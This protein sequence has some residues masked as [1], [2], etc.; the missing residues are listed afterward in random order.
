MWNSGK[1]IVNTLKLRQNKKYL[2]QYIVA[3]TALTTLSYSSGSPE[4]ESE[5]DHKHVNRRYYDSVRFRLNDICI[6]I[7]HQT[8]PT[9]CQCEHL[10]TRNINLKRRSTLL[11]LNENSKPIS[12][13]KTKYKVSWKTPIGEGAFSTV[14][15]ATNRSTMDKVAIKKI[16]KQFTDSDA[17]QNE[18]DAL[19]KIQENGG[20]PN[21]CSLNESFEDGKNFYLVL[22]LVNGGEMFDHLIKLGAYSEADSARL[23]REA[24]KA[25]CFIHGIGVVHGDLKPENLML[26]TDRSEDGTIKLVDFGCAHIISDQ[27]K[28]EPKGSEKQVIGGNTPAYC[29][30]EALVRTNVDPLKPS[31]DMWAL[32]IILYIML[33]GLHPFDMAGNASDEEIESRIKAREDPPL[34]N[35]PITAHLSQSAIDVIEMCIKWDANERITAQQ[36]LDHPWVRGDTAS[37]SKMT[38]ASKKLKMYQP[39]KSKLEAK[40]FA[41][42]FSWSDDVRDSSI[43]KKTSLVERAFIAIDTNN[44]GFLTSDD[45]QRHCSKQPGDSSQK[46]EG[47]NGDNPEQQK[48][49]S[50][51]GFEN[52][53]G[54]NMKNKY[55]PRGM[56]I[57][58]E[59][60]IGNHMYFIN[61]GMIEVKTKDGSKALRRQGDFFGEGALL[62]SKKLRSASIH[63]VTPVHAIE[64]SREY[65]EKYVTSSDLNIDLKEKD[66]TRKRNRAKTILRLQKNLKAITVN[67]GH[68]VFQE[69]DHADSLY[70]LE[71]G[72]VD[73]EVD[74]KKVFGVKPGD[75]FGEHSIIMR[76][77]RNTTAICKS[78]KCVVQAMA[79]K[80][81]DDVYNSSSSLKSSLRELCLRREFQKALVKKTKKEFP[82]VKDLRKVFDAADIEE[83]GFLNENQIASLL[84]S[85]D[86]SLSKEEIKE[87][88]M[89]L[90]LDETGLISFDE[91]KLIFGMNESRAAS[92]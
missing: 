2:C 68:I 82:S 27:D 58:E 8:S 88:V 43:A 12:S 73:V 47:Q 75:I 54:E 56:T 39:F 85:F 83:A 3:A 76:R 61:S 69:G 77:P 90:D 80:D 64:I 65:F 16:P 35:S 40:V 14:F 41:D 55:F 36:L 62:H 1:A 48:A 50:L 19:L 37:E 4:S 91:F 13:L 9:I 30:P 71:S 86:P 52:L 45:L 31:I 32:G 89:S 84:T 67:Q 17:F 70:I 81:F 28:V 26:S 6:N 87:V 10:M 7:L 20:H 24:C 78:H 49:M 46:E 74:N 34:R 60:D 23:V 44:Q 72:L 18:M 59:G 22:D 51:T 53:L 5:D 38:D 25:L 29:P 79:A 15:V 21:C 57:Y 33:T 11:K 66:K 42:F 92:M 63:C